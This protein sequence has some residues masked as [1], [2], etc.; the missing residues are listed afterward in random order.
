[1]HHIQLRTISILDGARVT[2]VIHPET[3][4][5]TTHGLGACGDP[6]LPYLDHRS[7]GFMLTIG[8][9][10]ESPAIYKVNTRGERLASG[11]F[12]S[13]RVPW[14]ALRADDF[15]PWADVEEGLK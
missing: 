11:R 13:R 1:M 14:G 4:T 3:K 9:G 2:S 7:E 12:P 10:V 6:I 5:K 15:D 8:E